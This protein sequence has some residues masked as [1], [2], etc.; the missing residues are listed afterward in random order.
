MS[1]LVSFMFKG[2]DL[3]ASKDLSDLLKRLKIIY[4]FM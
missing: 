2:R 3:I 1:Y 4:N